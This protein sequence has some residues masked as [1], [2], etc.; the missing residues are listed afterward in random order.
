MSASAGPFFDG[1]MALEQ[2]ELASTLCESTMGTPR[3]SE[4]EAPEAVQANTLT[5]TSTA[6]ASAMIEEAR[7]ALGPNSLEQE[8]RET[9]IAIARQRGHR[10]IIRP[11]DV[12]LQILCALC[13]QT[14]EVANREQTVWWSYPPDW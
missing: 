7:A 5:Q 14:V 3:N 2:T 9:N 13:H 12:V 10:L 1:A 4:V 8:L 6:A 11:R